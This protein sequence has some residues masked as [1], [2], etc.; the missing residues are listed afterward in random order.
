MSKTRSLTRRLIATVLLLEF[1]SAGALIGASAIYEW[2]THLR[3]FDIMLRGQAD[4]LLGAVGDA[5]DPADN[6]VLDMAGIAI[7]P[8]DSYRVEDEKGRILGQ[9]QLAIPPA[10]LDRLTHGDGIVDANVHGRR[11]RLLRISALRVVDPGEA[12]GGVRHTIAVFYGAPT[13]RIR[14]EVEEAVRFYSITAL[15]LLAATAAAMVW[16]MRRGLV[17]LRQL[18]EEAGKVSAA[19]WSFHPPAA[20]TETAEL[21]PL[22]RAIET[23][24]ARL[25]RSFAQQRR[26][27]SD[28]AH[29]LK[30]DVAIAK[31]SLQ[32]L[33]MRSR[34]A[35]EYQAG[36]ELCFRDCM[37]LESTVQ[38]MLTLARVEH[39]NGSALEARPLSCSVA[40]C[41]RTAIQQTAS[42]ADLRRVRVALRIDGDACV[43][44]DE[45][46]CLLVFANLLLNAFQHSP[47]G[48][49]VTVSM[50]TAPEG[51]TVVIADE[52]E[53]VPPEDLPHLF[54]PF[55]RADPSRARSSGGTGLGLAIS[56]AI[57][58]KIG[59][60]IAIDNLAGSGAAVTIHLPRLFVSYAAPEL[61]R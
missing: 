49:V 5:D 45:R 30:T 50:E 54:E 10:L 31:S 35:E 9:S 18:A 20:A 37:R 28:A 61:T 19:D 57:C 17:P 53:G 33:T 36:L 23:A 12:G 47:A 7:P 40:D 3:A 42:F 25:E 6:V 22:V 2:R 1:I 38:Q 32:L 51:A 58:E 55:Y 26:F 15:L 24:L 27:T 4:T 13:G 41:L 56:K 46:D 8:R 48:S 16:L 44:I 39:A 43:E 11:Y 14:H 34:T 52:G 60:S 21:L 29:E 59:G